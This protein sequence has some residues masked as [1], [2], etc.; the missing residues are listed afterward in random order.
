MRLA[1]S[2]AA[3]GVSGEIQVQQLPRACAPQIGKRRS[4][5]DPELPL[6]YAWVQIFIGQEMLPRS[7]SP[8]RRSN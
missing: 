2:Q 3:D 6:P 7:F 5:D 8:L 1:H 4:L